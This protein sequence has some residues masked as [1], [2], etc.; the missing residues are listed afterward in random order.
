MPCAD[1]NAANNSGDS[2]VT[3]A[4]GEDASADDAQSLKALVD[5]RRA[6]TPP[7]QPQQLDPQEQLKK[8]REAE[9]AAAKLLR[10]LEEEAAASG[11]GEGQKGKAKKKEKKKTRGADAA[12]GGELG[13]GAAEG[14]AGDSAGCMPAGGEADAPGAPQKAAKPSIES[15]FQD[16]IQRA[17][18]GTVDQQIAGLRDLSHNIEQAS[19]K[20]VEGRIGELAGHVQMVLTSLLAVQERSTSD[21]HLAKH[22]IH[23]L[24]NVFEMHPSAAFALNFSAVGR[25]LEESILMSIDA[26]QHNVPGNHMAGLYED[27]IKRLD[28]MMRYILWLANPNHCFT[29]FIRFLYEGATLSGKRAAS[30][31]FV[32]A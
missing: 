3:A 13:A 30:T 15:I 20:M 26:S 18:S 29:L 12:A 7:V 2:A 5:Q 14:G 23:T 16:C 19:T 21:I 8:E 27:M 24:H 4:A 11:G 31:D 28:A 22:A 1:V 32:E 10:R 17:T 6:R 9:L 25:L